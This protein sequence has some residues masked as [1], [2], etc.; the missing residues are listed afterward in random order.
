MS[1]SQWKAKKLDDTANGQSAFEFLF[2][3]IALSNG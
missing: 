2:D 1:D 3:T